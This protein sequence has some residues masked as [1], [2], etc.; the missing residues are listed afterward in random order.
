M[1]EAAVLIGAYLL[2]SIPVAWLIFR[3]R[4]GGDLRRVGDGNVGA[5]NAAREGAGHAA[6]VAI[7]LADIG[8][9]LLAVAIARW[10]GLE[11]G[12]WAAAGAL[13]MVGHMFPIFLRFD[14]GRAAATALGASGAF[15]PL[16][17]GVTFVVG[18]LT[19]LATRKAE[20][21]ILLVA[22]PLPFLAIAFSYPPEVI[23]FCFAAPIAAG[24]KAGLDRYLRGRQ[25]EPA[26][27][28]A[29]ES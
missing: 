24:I 17:F 4:T 26:V 13:V 5:A 28:P 12:W 9:G 1:T 3:A 15:V 29:A 8:K 6:G 27:E 7:I 19:Y 11:Q 25:A 21:G 16:Q 18:G 20:L 22:A 10:A 2:G 23:G 14:G